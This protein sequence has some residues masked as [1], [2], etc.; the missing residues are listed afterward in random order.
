MIDYCCSK[1][2]FSSVDCVA[3]IVVVLLVLVLCMYSTVNRKII[4]IVVGARQNFILQVSR[5]PREPIHHAGGLL[6]EIK[7]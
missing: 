4:V 5:H 6:R 3:V 2:A 7:Q 1:N